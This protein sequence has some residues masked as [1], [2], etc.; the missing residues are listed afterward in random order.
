[1]SGEYILLNQLLN[2]CAYCN[3]PIQMN[4]KLM[5]LVVSNPHSKDAN[6]CKSS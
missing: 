6:R 2:S 1:M 5:K 4:I 3:V